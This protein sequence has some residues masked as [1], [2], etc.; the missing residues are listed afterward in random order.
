MQRGTATDLTTLPASPALLWDADDTT[1]APAPVVRAQIL[2]LQAALCQLPGAVFG[3]SA[4]CPVRHTFAD[5]IYCREIFIPAGTVIVGKIHKHAHPNFLLRGEVTV[6]TEGGGR[7]HLVAP[8]ALIS[9]PGTKRAVYAHTDTVWVTVHT[10][11]DE[12]RDL[13][14]LETHIIAP[15]YAALAAFQAA[16]QEDLP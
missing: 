12:T 11:P 15:D 16:Q 6:I 8:L 1:R 7:E 13:T 9:Q 5:G 10:N 14:A 4:L 3:D 2:A